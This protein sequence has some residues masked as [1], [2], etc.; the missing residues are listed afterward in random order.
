M[1]EG[2][3]LGAPA[4]RDD[5]DDYGYDDQPVFVRE[6]PAIQPRSMVAGALVA[7]VLGGAAIAAYAAM[8]GDDSSGAGAAGAMSTTTASSPARPATPAPPASTPRPTSARPS[9]TTSTTSTP[10][11]ATFSNPPSATSTAPPAPSLPT[12]ND[13]AIVS[14]NHRADTD[15]A[16]TPIDGRWVVQLDSKYVGVRDRS[17]QI[18]RFTARDIWNRFQT[19]ISD[20]RFGGKVRIVRD[21][22]FGTRVG[23]DGKTTWIALLDLDQGSKASA[24]AWCEANFTERGKALANV[25]F[26]RQITP[27]RG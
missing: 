13:Q 25:C 9:T 4:T 12:S 11:P 3:G 8:R 6:E 24:Q 7:V 17:Q 21:T 5:Y 20:P 15:E 1:V 18:E 2:T 23:P 26:P 16:A 19:V 14:L 27:P 10:P 22:H